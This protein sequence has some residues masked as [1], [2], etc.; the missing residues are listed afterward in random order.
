MHERSDETMIWTRQG[1]A[2]ELL[3]LRRLVPDD[4]LQALHFVNNLSFGDSYFRFGHPGYQFSEAAMHRQCHADP[5]E[6][7]H[8]I[9]ALSGAAGERVIAAADCC[10]R[11]E[12]DACE[13]ALLVAEDWR[14]RGLARW[15][16]ERLVGCAR[17]QGVR[18]MVGKALSSN[19]AMLRLARRSGFV[20]VKGDDDPTVTHLIMSLDETR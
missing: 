3:T 1:P 2:G 7:Q 20:L 18:R 4:A 16:L 11:V 8:Y 17:E 14:R 10:L 19:A 12:P 5:R 15:L 9:V 6:S 13:F